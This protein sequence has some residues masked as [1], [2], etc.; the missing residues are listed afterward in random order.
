M[1]SVEA[2]TAAVAG[3][4]SIERELGT[5]A[6]A[7]VYLARDIKH[8]RQVAIKVLRSDLT[9][10]LAAERFLREIEIAARLQHP[11]ILGLIDSGREAG[12]LYYVMPYVDG[13]SLRTR[14]SRE[15]ELSIATGLR[16]LDGVAQALA[17]AHARGVVHR[18]VKP[19]NILLTDYSG[20]A[21]GGHSHA[22]VADFGI[23]KAIT[24]AAEA[25]T[26]S[27]S[28]TDIGVAVGTPAYMAPEQ[29]SADRQ[30]DQRAD[31]Y[32]FGV[33]AYEIFGGQPPFSGP[34]AQHVIAAHMTEVPPALSTLRPAIPAG[35][36][37]LI[38]RCVEKRPADRWQ[39]ADDIVARLDNV[40]VPASAAAPR[41]RSHK[42][43]AERSFRL[44]AD[45][46]RQLDRRTLDPRL[47]GAEMRYVDNLAPSDTAVFFL[48]GLG[49][50]DSVFAPLLREAPYRGIGITMYGFE[51]AAR[52]RVPLSGAD[53]A[54]LVRELIRSIVEQD[55]PSQVILVGF[56]SGA[57]LYLEM[58]AAPAY[59]ERP[60]PIA[61]LIDL[62]PNLSV[63]TC[64]VSRVFAKLHSGNENALLHDLSDFATGA[65]SLHE[66]LNV[67]EY[68]VRTLRKFQAD[69]G[70]LQR[71]NADVFGA[72]QKRGMDQFIDWYRC[73]TAQVQRA[74]FVFED[75][76][77][78]NRLVQELRLR[79]FDEGVLG[80]RYRDDS[81]VVEP[82][83]DHFDLARPERLSKYIDE[84]L[85]CLAVTSG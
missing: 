34:S 2:V 75:T 29:A 3:R 36:E 49:Q 70:P 83:A 47:I 74:V 13:E 52:Q 25:G 77:V 53:H 19:E 54:V 80:E 81:L 4:Y 26:S 82:G 57:D 73:A 44:T 39:T 6:M 79:N 64:F 23:A 85:A 20:R 71:Y 76:E 51:Q 62:S 30:S 48:H 10:T 40:V 15:G 12:V 11:N 63:E 65:K 14:L 41:D 21:S 32:S 42:R 78:C 50:D 27:T 7:T 24:T 72:F 46:C 33:V 31:I 45:V 43:L 84:M 38:M 69:P 8:S 58:L 60:L 17:Y 35:L 18:D 67:H 5:G 59:Q 68:L 56:S 66:W 16:I 1:G 61:G 9:A 37:D 22:L 55:H 28:L